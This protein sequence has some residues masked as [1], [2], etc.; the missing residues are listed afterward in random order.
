MKKLALVAI[1]LF[2]MSCTCLFCGKDQIEDRASINTF[3]I[4]EVICFFAQENLTYESVHAFF[5]KFVIFHRVNVD[6]Q[7]NL[8]RYALCNH[9]VRIECQAIVEQKFPGGQID[10]TPYFMEMMA[11]EYLSSCESSKTG[12][13]DK[14]SG[15]IPRFISG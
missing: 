11:Y 6:K 5:A 3:S 15:E 7:L 1:T 10:L 12:K 8:P 13:K 4:E 9:H 2:A 14:L